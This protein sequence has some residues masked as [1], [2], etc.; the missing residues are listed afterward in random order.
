MQTRLE[1]EDTLSFRK[2][3]DHVRKYGRQAIQCVK[4]QN[5]T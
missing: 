2:T 3:C 1:E 5:V 4:Q